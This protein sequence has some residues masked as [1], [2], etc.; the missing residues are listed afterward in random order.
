L[1]IEK[2]NPNL[3]PTPGDNIKSRKRLVVALYGFKSSG[4]TLVSALYYYTETA[5]DTIH[6]I[7][8][9]IINGHGIMIFLLFKK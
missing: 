2:I 8:V 3:L 1:K 7:T 9:I 4:F 6:P 5:T